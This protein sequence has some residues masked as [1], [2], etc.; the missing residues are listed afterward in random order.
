M[1]S[2]E[3]CGDGVNGALRDWPYSFLALFHGFASETKRPDYDFEFGFVVVFVNYFIGG[4]LYV[5]GFW[6]SDNGWP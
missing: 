4:C 6:L 3:V 1:L 2:Q 5:L